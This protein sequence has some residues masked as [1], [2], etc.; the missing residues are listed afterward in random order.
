MR[1]A[2]LGHGNIGGALGR[3]FVQSGHDVVFGSR[4]PADLHDL[5]ALLGEHGEATTL[6]KAI[7][8]ADTI[9]EALPFA[10]SFA[11]APHAL[12][13]KTLISASNYYPDRDGK[14]D[15]GDRLDTEALAERLP[16]TRVVKAFSTLYFKE[17]EARIDAHPEPSVL[18]LAGNDEEARAFTAALITSI[19]FIP[20]DLGTLDHAAPFTA[21]GPL[22]N[23]AMTEEQA[24]EAVRAL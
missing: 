1:I 18:F 14:I 22:Y 4:R 11:L 9:V 19:G 21:G 6:K 24:L 12:A 8:A 7:E 3:L 13:G 17:L 2:V 16:K 10:A 15:L 20:I 5:L 23:R